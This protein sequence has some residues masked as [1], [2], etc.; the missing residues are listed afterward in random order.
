MLLGSASGQVVG[1]GDTQIVALVAS[2][3][4]SGVA[5]VQQGGAWSNAVKFE[6]PV[7]SG[8]A[9]VVVPNVL[10]LSAG[11]THALQAL[12]A[13]GHAVTGLSWTSSDNSV[14]T[15]ADG[16][17]TAVAA[18]HV[19]GDS[20]NGVGRRDGVGGCVARRD[21]DLVEPGRRF[22]CQ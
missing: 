9:A 12:D 17:V 5:R 11:E 8:S 16:V 18:G 19:D 3:S 6:V 4:V 15:V 13:S 20:G 2:G 21:G 14:A 10:N 22:R 1:W 7:P